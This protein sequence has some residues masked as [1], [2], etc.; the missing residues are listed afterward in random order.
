MRL[1]SIV[2]KPYVLRW[3]TLFYLIVESGQRFDKNVSSLIAKFVSTSGEKV[4]RLIQIEIKVAI[5]MSSH[6]LVD[7][8][9][10]LCMEVLEFVQITHHI[11]TVGSDDVR[12]TFDQMFGFL[13]GNF[14]YRGK[15]MG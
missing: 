5:K 11:Q 7:F 2:F 12:F 4:E 9:F 1:I 13:T 14:G 6:K 15:R 10:K 8:F 3:C